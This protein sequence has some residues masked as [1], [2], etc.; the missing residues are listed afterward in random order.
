MVKDSDKNGIGT[1]QKE[2]GKT[3]WKTHIKPQK[4]MYIHGHTYMYVYYTGTHTHV[5]LDVET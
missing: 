3:V 5:K 4:F 2:G 1:V